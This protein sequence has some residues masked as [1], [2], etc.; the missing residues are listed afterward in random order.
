[1]N[2]IYRINLKLKDSQVVSLTG[3]PI[4]VLASRADNDS[5]DLWYEHYEDIELS[6]TIYFAVTGG[7]VPW[8]NTAER[9][10]FRH[11]GTF[12]ALDG[13]HVG[14]VYVSDVG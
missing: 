12:V 14:H 2:S 11:L 9:S 10:M 4:S 6:Y 13:Y 1:M 5:F 8:S 3:P 7:R